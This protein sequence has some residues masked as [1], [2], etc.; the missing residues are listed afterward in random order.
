MKPVLRAAPTRSSV[1][2]D[3]RPEPAFGDAHATPY[4]TSIE[5]RGPGAST[6]DCEEPPGAGNAF[7]FALFPDLKLDA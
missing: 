2:V 6:F 3:N 7:E 5:T 1:T 4:T